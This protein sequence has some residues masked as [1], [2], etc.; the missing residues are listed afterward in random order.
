MSQKTWEMKFVCIY[1]EWPPQC[2]LWG[3]RGSP[4]TGSRAPWGRPR[5]GPEYLLEGCGWLWSAWPAPSGSLWWLPETLCSLAGGF[6][7]G[8]GKYLPADTRESLLTP[9]TWKRVVMSEMHLGLFE[10]C[11]CNYLWLSGMCVRMYFKRNYAW[12]KNIDWKQ[13]RYESGMRR[14]CTHPCI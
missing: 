14:P 11:K 7:W 2:H 4:G 12:D 9:V 13:A 8:E 6:C 5:C 3:S 10:L 1:L